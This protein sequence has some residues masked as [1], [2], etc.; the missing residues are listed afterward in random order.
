MNVSKLFTAL[1]LVLCVTGFCMSNVAAGSH[2]D[3]TWSVDHD[4]VWWLNYNIKAYDAENT[5]IDTVAS[6]DRASRGYEDSGYL[7]IG[8][9][10][11]TVYVKCVSSGF[12][13]KETG[14][15]SLDKS[16]RLSTDNIITNR[17]AKIYIDGEVARTFHKNF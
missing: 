16:V 13:G 17:I 6:A 5:L 4:G 12:H 11:V 3:K 15:L 10:Y 14:Q 1:F 8:T 2:G 7:P 9:A